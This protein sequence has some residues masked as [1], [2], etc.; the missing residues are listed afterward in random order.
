MTTSAHVRMAP[1]ARVR[2]APAAARVHVHAC[3]VVSPRADFGSF[4]LSN[5][6]CQL[7]HAY[8]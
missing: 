7:C 4:N 8:F 1:A 3:A 5:C 2:M 6:R